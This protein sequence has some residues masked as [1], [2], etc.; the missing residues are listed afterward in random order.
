MPDR[1]VPSQFEDRSFVSLGMKNQFERHSKFLSLV[2]RHDPSAMG[3]E[4]DPKGWAS[5]EAILD[6]FRKKKRPLSREQ[7]ET[8]VASDEKGRYSFSPDGRSI[9]ANQG[10]SIP[11]DLG[12]EAL[13]PPVVLYHGTATRFL[14]SV[15]ASGLHAGNRQHV[16]LSTNVETAISVGQRHGKAVVLQVDAEAMSKD[17]IE[18]YLSD[19]GVWLTDA[20]PSRYLEIRSS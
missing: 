18:F 10:H 16:H 4:L 2:L 14:D 7:L 1:K 19:N 6:G 8:L 12:L 3:I 15:M 13:E 9:R 20:V 11:I 5:V 17:G